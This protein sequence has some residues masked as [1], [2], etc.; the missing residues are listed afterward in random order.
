MFLDWLTIFLLR[1]KAD[2]RSGQLVAVA[3]STIVV[4]DMPRA[5]AGA[6]DNSPVLGWVLHPDLGGQADPQYL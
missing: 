2:P 4:R 5:I 3:G 6:L 1:L